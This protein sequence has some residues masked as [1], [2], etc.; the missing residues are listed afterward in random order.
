MGLVQQ[1]IPDLVER[2]V[3]YILPFILDKIDFLPRLPLKLFT[4]SEHSRENTP[5]VIEGKSEH[6]SPV[7]S[8]PDMASQPVC[9]ATVANDLTVA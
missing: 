4:V 6:D 8:S 3:N 2:V 9:L 5:A 1:G 7:G